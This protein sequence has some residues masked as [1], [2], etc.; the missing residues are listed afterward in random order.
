MSE[1]SIL[2]SQMP[3]VGEEDV[4]MFDLPQEPHEIVERGTFSEEIPTYKPRFA[5]F[6]CSVGEVWIVLL[7]YGS[8]Y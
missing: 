6:A 5:E 4:T 8:R 1:E 3:S 2:A 7:F